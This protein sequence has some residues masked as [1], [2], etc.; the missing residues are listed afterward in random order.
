[1]EEG[2]GAALLHWSD[3]SLVTEIERW[4]VFSLVVIIEI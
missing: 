3:V 2:T 4:L 1:M